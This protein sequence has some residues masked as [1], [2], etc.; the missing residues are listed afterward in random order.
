MAQTKVVTNKKDND[1]RTVEQGDNLSWTEYILIHYRW[2]I[3]I[4]FL[5]PMSV[6]Y[7]CLYFARAW[8]IFKLASAPEKH[9]E[10]VGHVQKQV[11]IYFCLSKC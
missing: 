4:L 8:I 11:R 9:S 7:D 1:Q 5:L 2:V 10:K 3:V 6:I